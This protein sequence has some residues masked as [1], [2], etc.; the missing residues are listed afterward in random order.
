MT[1]RV[2]DLCFDA[3]RWRDAVERLD[4]DLEAL[5]ATFDA[6]EDVSYEQADNADAL[7]GN[8]RSSGHGH[9]LTD[10]ARCCAAGA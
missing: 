3:P 4:A 9:L 5:R 6:I 10:G 8:A 7:I 1:G 2:W